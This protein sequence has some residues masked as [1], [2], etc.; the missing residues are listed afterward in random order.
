M[1]STYCTITPHPPSPPCCSGSPSHSLKPHTA[2]VPNT[3]CDPSMPHQVFKPGIP[4]CTL[5]SSHMNV[6]HHTGTLCT[7]VQCV[8]LTH[9]A[10]QPPPHTT[11]VAPHQSRHCAGPSPSKY[12]S[13]RH[14]QLHRLSCSVLPQEWGQATEAGG[15]HRAQEL[16]QQQQK[17]KRWG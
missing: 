10:A 9:L 4:Q 13:H 16:Q 17:S 15:G 1:W 11:P 14:P 6:P 2:P 3:A 8:A 5:L 12:S 7:W